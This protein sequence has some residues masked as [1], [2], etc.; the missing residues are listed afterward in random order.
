MDGTGGLVEEPTSLSTRFPFDQ[1]LMLAGLSTTETNVGTQFV[2][3]RWQGFRKWSAAGFHG[4]L[5]ALAGSG[6]WK[7]GPP[8]A[9]ILTMPWH[10]CQT[11]LSTSSIFGIQSIDENYLEEFQLQYCK[12]SGIS[13][14]RTKGF[15]CLGS[16]SCLD[17]QLPP[18]QAGE[19]CDIPG[20]D[21]VARD[22][23]TRLP[24]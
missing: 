4:S 12:P 15:A 13:Y 21:A 22:G 10:G 7:L 5:V 8:A 20:C 16:D 1:W 17:R 6:N 2:R 3:P 14:T 18:P 24:G 19:T 23:D 11:I 9:M